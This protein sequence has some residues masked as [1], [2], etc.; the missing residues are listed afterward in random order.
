MK[1]IPMRD[2]QPVELKQRDHAPRYK[3]IGAKQVLIFH[4]NI[5]RKYKSTNRSGTPLIADKEDKAAQYL[6]QGIEE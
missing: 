6:D 1:D 5:P 4:L 3:N 2:N